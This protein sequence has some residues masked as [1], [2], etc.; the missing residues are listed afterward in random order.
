MGIPKSHAQ[1]KVL[2]LVVETLADA[3]ASLHACD[4]SLIR[5]QDELKDASYIRKRFSEEGMAFLTITLPRLGDWM[6]RFVWGHDIQR[7]EGFKP[8]DGLFP[9]FLRPFWIFLKRL[10]AESVCA[11]DAEVYRILRTL[12]L[13]L[14]KLDV[15]CRPDLVE[16]KMSSFLQI[17]DELSYFEV[18]PNLRLGYAQSAMEMLLSG[19]HPVVNT[20]KHGPGAVAGGERHNEKWSWTTLYESVH[21]E[22]PYYEYFYS[23]RSVIGGDT[24]RRARPLQ[25]A[26]SA[27]E[28]RRLVR[29]KEPTARLLTVPKD[30]RG[31]RI[32]SC[33]PKELMYLQQGVSCHLMDYIERHRYTQGHVNFERQDINASLALESSLSRAKDTIDMSDAS[34]RVSVA[35]VKYLVPERISRRWLALRSTATCLPDGSLLPLSKFAPMGSALCFPVE[36]L[37]F[38]SLAVGTIW[39]RTGSFELACSSV[40]VYGDDII[41]AGGHT[42]E[43]MDV[44]ESVALKVNRQ[45]SFIGS[46]PF[47]ESCGIEAFKGFNVTPFR[48][49]NLPPQRPS[50]GTAIAAWVRY[51]ENTQYV[52]PRRSKYQLQV[53]ERL[54][55]RIPR[56]PS[57]QAFL[58]LVTTV[59][60]WTH[61]EYNDLR[62][63]DST[64]YWSCRLV[65]VKSKQRESAI[66]GWS[67]LQRNLVQ[68][69]LEGSPS[70]V[71][72]RS[73][74]Q[75][76]KKRVNVTYLG[77]KVK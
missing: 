65:V 30:S 47:R 2:D 64:S 13:G 23:V 8:Y 40:W 32:I 21:A 60:V 19:Y 75:I 72:D 67:R 27:G 48:V 52:C 34:D 28:Y 37:V 50:D 70:K 12:L 62:W 61:N 42:E 7:V 77:I 39:H 15:P 35:L 26:A 18:C 56:T 66:P 45:K 44:L 31:P 25:L 53:V 36:S 4:P 16:A 46:H 54:I 57:P 73:S 38:W 55:G 1:D 6:D 29:E 59:D 17:E 68:R 9:V 20:P 49:K 69:V 76:S 5:L 3:Y 22:F 43:V 41:I 11:A 24:V 33:E 10:Q 63:S 58:S 51:C 74:T 14:K 71:V